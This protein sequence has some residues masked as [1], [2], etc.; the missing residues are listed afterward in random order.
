MGIGKGFPSGGT[1]LAIPSIR[2][3][4]LRISMVAIPIS[5]RRARHTGWFTE[6]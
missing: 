3:P 6:E 4:T 2:F 5:M 1:T